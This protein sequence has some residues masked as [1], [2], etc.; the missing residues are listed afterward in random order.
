MGKK[1]ISRHTPAA[2]RSYGQSFLAGRNFGVNLGHAIGFEAG[3]DKGYAEGSTLGYN[4][5]F[6][7]ALHLLE[8]GEG[9]KGGGFTDLLIDLLAGLAAGGAVT[10]TLT[11]GASPEAAGLFA[12]LGIP[13]RFGGKEPGP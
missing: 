6:L 2:R 9:A 4:N 8:E 7:Q 12:L 10:V 5:G 3:Y 1:A 13:V 11:G